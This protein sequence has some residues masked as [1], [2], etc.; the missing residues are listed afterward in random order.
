MDRIGYHEGAYNMAH[1]FPI[2]A[3]YEKE[4]GWIMYPFY[5]IGEPF[6]SEV[7]EYLFG[8]F[9]KQGKLL[10]F[11][12][13]GEGAIKKC[14]K[15]AGATNPEEA[16]NKSIRGSYGRILT[17]GLYENVVHVS[18]TKSE[19]QR[20]IKLWF[21]GSSAEDISQYTN[22][23]EKVLKSDSPNELKWKYSDEPN[24]KHNTIF[25]ATKEKALKWIL[26]K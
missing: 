18:S 25:R 5:N 24:E 20:E 4:S 9:H 15:V 6:Y 16:H 3:V 14:R 12:Y 21:A 19:A 23:F 7:I 2:A 8:K 11:I 13:Y 22:E 26:N 17:S 10:A 1:W